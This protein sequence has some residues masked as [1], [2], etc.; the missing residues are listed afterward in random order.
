[1][2]QD[3]RPDDVGLAYAAER[4]FVGDDVETMITRCRDRHIRA[5]TL[6]AGELGLAATWRTWCDLE[7]KFRAERRGGGQPAT[8][9]GSIYDI[10]AGRPLPR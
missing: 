5:G 8:G 3:W 6:I 10:A 7:V 2:P 4:G 1:M 9:R